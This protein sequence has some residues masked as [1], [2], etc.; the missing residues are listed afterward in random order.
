V[1]VYPKTGSINDRGG[2]FLSSD[3]GQNFETQNQG[4]P[5][6][7]KPSALTVNITNP[8]GESTDVNFFL[9]SFE[10][11]SNGAKIYKITYIVGIEQISSEIPSQYIL[12]QNY[13]NPFNPS[14]KIDFA[15]TRKDFV[16]LKIFNSLGKEVADLVNDDLTPGSYSYEFNAASLTSGLYF[17]KLQTGGF[18]ET[19]KMLL[20]K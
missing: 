18:T 15:I 8:R 17:Y 11:S 4:L 6:S 2:F 9:G 20:I 14:T 10:N 13:P 5:L 16:S 3:G 12:K 19:R 1:A 7:A